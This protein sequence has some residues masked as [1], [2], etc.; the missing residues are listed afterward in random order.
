MYEN[1]VVGFFLNK[2]QSL[3]EIGMELG[4]W[5]SLKI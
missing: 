5:S 2:L 3:E 4:N 1:E